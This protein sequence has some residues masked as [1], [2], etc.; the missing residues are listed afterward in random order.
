MKSRHEQ[1]RL[2]GTRQTLPRPRKVL[3]STEPGLCRDG[4]V[5]P[6]VFEETT[7][8]FVAD[9]FSHGSWTVAEVSV[10]NVLREAIMERQFST[11]Y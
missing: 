4:Q 3:N 1:D 8:T 6:S 10:V 9:G 5:V 2:G 11:L 7:D